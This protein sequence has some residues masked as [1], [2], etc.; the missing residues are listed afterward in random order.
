[1]AQNARRNETPASNFLINVITITG[2]VIFGVALT[3][4][5][6]KSFN[7]DW[8]LLSAVTILV[9]SRTDSR[10][11]KISTTVT[12]DD[13][14]I[15]A[16][17]FHN[18]LMP[19]I[20]LAGINAAVCSLNYP[21]KRKVVPFNAAVMSLSVLVSGFIVTRLF[22]DPKLLTNNFGRLL[23]AAEV[24]AL[25]QYIVNS[26]LVNAV[27]ALR[28]KDN[29]LQ[30][31]RDSVLWTSVSYFVGAIA[32]SLV[33]KLIGLVSIYAIIIAVPILA[34]TY[35]T[36]KNYLEKVRTSMSHAEEMADLHLRTIE[37]LAIAIDAKD[38]VTHDHVHR[39][40]I[41][42]EGLAKHFGLSDKE[43]EAL[44][45]GALLHDIGKMAV[46]DYI[47]N[48]PGKLTPAEF[49]K[50]KV[51]TIVGAEILERV[52]FP[53]PVVPVVRHHHERWDGNGYPDGLKGE[54]I[55]LT[56]RILAVVD[57]FDS[58]REERG[59]R[60]AMTREEALALLESC[61]GAVYDPQIVRAFIDLLPEFEAEITRQ[62]IQQ[63][64]SEGRRQKAEGRSD[65]T[66]QTP[67]SRLQT[68][69]SPTPFETIRNAHREVMMLYN[70][71]QTIGTS[72][73]LRDT[74]AVFSSR[75]QDIVSY[76][77]CV[78]YLKSRGAKEL[79]AAHVAGRNAEVFKGRKIQAGTG[80]TGWV[81]AHAQ[82]MYNADPRL[83]FDALRIALN[84]NY[85]TLLAVPLVKDGEIFGALT[86]YSQEVAVYEPDH[87][88]LA[89]AVAKLASDAIANAIQHKQ[90]ET[91]A[92][93]D[94]LTGLANARALRLRFEEE[95][96]RSN[97]YHG[98]FAVLMMDLDGFKSVN[99][100]LGHQA[101]DVALKELAALLTT[102]VRSFDFLAR[103]AGDE[104]V[105]LAQ[106]LPEEAPNI[107]RRIQQTI[108]THEFSCTKA[109][110]SLGIS[111]GYAC[112]GLDGNTLDELLLAADREMYN[113][114]F[115]RKT[116]GIASQPAQ[117][118]EVKDI[119]L[120][121]YRVM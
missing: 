70:I 48:K 46:P 116:N 88:R 97:R 50:M 17:F 93:T 15:Y 1:M 45:A 98:A 34:I 87:L 110:K 41:Y 104:F 66:L 81:T 14:F 111:I 57:C 64:D 113:N 102:Q 101:G 67:D 18:G 79:E 23:L 75:L 121:S 52:N 91:N 105:I 20:V 39:V 47:L 94:Q 10:I 89:E 115:C 24:L 36:Y 3:R 83:D 109:G 16:A 22:D 62:N 56:A 19:A 77:T 5:D 35:L 82:P 37:A 95:V 6:T 112:Y 54:A 73:N 90:I 13:T 84:E 2:L 33:V 29:I 117:Q 49:E 32:A 59:Y 103:Y 40:Q 21:N 51:H 43:I 69:D 107:V 4:F 53:Y 96:S 7:L 63:P 78:L 30:R 120:S 72:L 60:L 92:L 28:G 58:A 119:D 100:T 61:S 86:L 12:L 108:D 42:A 85:L 76:T 25:V 55:P 99:D 68:P 80:L 11:P 114:K 31:W 65:Q 74:F 9:V 106:A 118:D 8:L 71:A 26:G 44:S 27:N 38:E